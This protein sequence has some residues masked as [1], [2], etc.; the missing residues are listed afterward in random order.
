MHL[1]IGELLRKLVPL[2]AHDVDEVLQEQRGTPHRFG[3]VAI[4]LGLCR[5]EHVWKAWAA[6]TTDTVERI[7]LK[8][9]GIDA[10]AAAILPH[11]VATR[12]GVIALR[13][14]PGLVVVATSDVCFEEASIALPTIIKRKIKFVLADAKQ[15]QEAVDFYYRKTA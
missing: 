9:V 5:P 4:S 13:T 7:D 10:Q 14:S 6:Q 8:D 3:E 12:F 11:D 15:I 2:S 1:R